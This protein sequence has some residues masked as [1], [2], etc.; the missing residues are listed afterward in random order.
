MIDKTQF[1]KTAT[2][3]RRETLPTNSR[4]KNQI[5]TLK[6][7]DFVPLLVNFVK[8]ILINGRGPKTDIFQ[9]LFL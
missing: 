8:N 1:T 7:L 2:I 9:K 6:H 5:Q 4:Q 3:H